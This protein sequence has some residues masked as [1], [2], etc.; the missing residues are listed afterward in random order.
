MGKKGLEH[1]IY[2]SFFLLVF[3]A[4]VKKREREMGATQLSQ[5]RKEEE[6]IIAVF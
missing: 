4:V 2:I 3:G 1:S 6:I 5:R